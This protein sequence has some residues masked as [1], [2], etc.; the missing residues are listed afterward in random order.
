MEFRISKET[1]LDALAK[2]QG[3]TGKKT[4]IQITS[5]VLISA[6]ESM[7]SIRATDLEMAFKASYEAEVLQ[8]GLTVVPSRKVYEIVRAFPSNMLAV[9]EIENKWIQMADNKVEYNIVG[10]EPE[11]FP[12]FPDI[13]DVEL[14]EIDV[15]VFRNMINKTIYSVLSDEG[16]VQ[17]GGVFFECITEDDIKK[18]RMVSTDGHRLSKIDYPIEEGKVVPLKEGVIIPRSG[19]M[20]VLKI[21]EGGKSVQIGFRE[22]S[23]VIKKDKEVLIIRLIEGEYP[24]YEMVIPKMGQNK[25]DVQREDLLMMLRRM[26]I[27][28]S[29]KYSGVRF[30][31]DK[32]QVEATVTNP[33]I[34]ESKEILSVSF[35]GEPLEVAFN[36]RYFID[37]LTSMD[38]KEVI[39]RFEDETKPCIIEGDGDPDFLGVIMPMR[40]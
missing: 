19:I 37:T 23:F 7:I 9:K 10:M 31:I 13:E 17:L 4:N 28:C 5:S 25:M 11:D 21:I 39:V 3:I 20:E 1:I 35:N 15:K 27:L 26:S 2:I 29:E 33:E 36:P 22:N 14:F 30:K 6:K 38:S 24:N 16:R 34:G 40:V 18:I 32:E 12:D 8:E